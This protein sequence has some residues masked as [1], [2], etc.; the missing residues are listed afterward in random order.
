[1]DL[2]GYCFWAKNYPEEDSTS[3]Y[4]VIASNTNAEGKALV[5]PISSVKFLD[6][7]SRYKLDGKFCKRYDEACVIRENEITKST[8]GNSLITKP[9]FIRY[10]WAKEVDIAKILENKDENLKLKNTISPD[11]L[12]R[13]QD[14]AK[15]SEELEPRFE[16]YFHLFME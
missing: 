4:I 2:S 1:M 6:C 16:K 10:D 3:H 5:V 12:K 13:I 8:N 11:L 15:I 14:G 7:Y 9:S